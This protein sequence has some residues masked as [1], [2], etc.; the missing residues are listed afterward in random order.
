MRLPRPSSY[1]PAQWH[2][3]QNTLGPSVPLAARRSIRY[4]NLALLP[5]TIFYMTSI[6][7]LIL[8]EVSCRICAWL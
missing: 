4:S 7:L 6:L 8:K 5:L 3:I 2:L 1:K